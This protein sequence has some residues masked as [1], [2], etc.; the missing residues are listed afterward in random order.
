MSVILAV[1]LKAGDRV[2]TG[3]RWDVTTPE[4]LTPEVWAFW[5]TCSGQRRDGEHVRV[6]VTCDGMPYGEWT[7]DHTW[8]RP[9]ADAIKR[10]RQDL[11]ETTP[12]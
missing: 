11:K 7:A 4:P 10:A 1:T 3:R 9:S 2:R 12:A 8:P 5:R 6:T